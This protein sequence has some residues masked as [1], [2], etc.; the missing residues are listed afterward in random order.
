MA[1]LR[2]MR[3]A[4]YPHNVCRLHKIIYGLKQAPELGA[5]TYAL[6]CSLLAL[7]H[8]VQ[9]CVS[10]SIPAALHLSISWSMLMI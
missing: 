8:P 3:N 6:S 2:G 9:T 7:L 5:R 1:Q 10:L 4:E